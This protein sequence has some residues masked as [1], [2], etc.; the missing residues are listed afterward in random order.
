MLEVQQWVK[1][2]EQWK[3]IETGIGVVVKVMSICL[4]REKWVVQEKVDQRAFYCSH[5]D[6]GLMA[7][8]RGGRIG[9]R[10]W[11]EQSCKTLCWFGYGGGT[12]GGIMSGALHYSVARRKHWKWTRLGMEKMG[13]EIWLG[14]FG[15]YWIFFSFA[16]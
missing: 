11:I 2:Q 13:I 1:S 9:D 5:T 12:Q 6:A 14:I 8:I 3:G 7:W 16:F 15:S 4:L 10:F